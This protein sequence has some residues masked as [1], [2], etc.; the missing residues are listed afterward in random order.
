MQ[1]SVCF[2][3]NLS[4]ILAQNH[5]LTSYPHIPIPQFITDKN[6]KSY[7]SCHI[8]T[9]ISSILSTLLEDLVVKKIVVFKSKFRIFF[10]NLENFDFWTNENIFSA[11][12]VKFGKN[13]K[14]SQKG[15]LLS[16]YSSQLRSKFREN[17]FS[18]F[19]DQ[20]MTGQTRVII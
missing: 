7:F 9:T 4:Q 1:R 5:I 18:G 17:I 10:E 20:L 13:K 11:C 12:L 6:E 2:F 14:F 8:Y 16:C 3:V 15:A 19:L